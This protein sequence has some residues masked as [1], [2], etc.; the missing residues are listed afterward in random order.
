[1][2]ELIFFGQ[3]IEGFS[4]GIGPK[5]RKSDQFMVGLTDLR[6]EKID[7][8]RSIATL[9]QI[10]INGRGSYSP[11]RM[12]SDHPQ[13]QIVLLTLENPNQ[14]LSGSRLEHSGS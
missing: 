11:L 14:H 4:I 12:I 1:M 2:S 5:S 9:E 10:T 7:R 6:P 13:D 8:A 3:S